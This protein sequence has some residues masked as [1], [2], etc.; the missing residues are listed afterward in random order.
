VPPACADYERTIAEAVAPYLDAFSNYG[1]E[2][3][4]D[5]KLLLFRSNRGGRSSQL[6][7]APAGKPAARP[8]VIAEAKDGVA[9]ARFTPDGRYLLFLRDRDKDE[10]TQIYRATP[11]GKE[12]R[13]LTESPQAYHR[14][15]EVTADGKTLF[16]FTGTHS[17][18]GITLVSQSIEGGAARKIFEGQ[19]FH[20][21][22]AITRDGRQALVFTLKS[23]SSSALMRV[24]LTSGATRTLAPSEGKQAHAHLSAFSA[25]EKSVYVVTDEDVERAGLHRIDL[26]S[27]AVLARYHDPKAEVADVRVSPRARVVAVQLDAGSHHLIKLL[28]ATTLKP[29]VTVRLPKGSV[30]LG[31]FSADGKGL[32]ITLSVPDAPTDVHYL[33]VGGGVRPLRRDARPGLAKLAKINVRV[34]WVPSTDDVHVPIN[35]YQPRPL[36]DKRLPVIVSVHGGPAAASSIGWSPMVSFWVS[37]G[38]AVVEPNVRGSTGFGKAYEKADNGRK[39]LN[40]LKDLAA[41][42]EWTRRQDWADPQRMVVFGASYGGYM[43]YMALGHQP[44]RWQ[45]GLGAVGV[46][47]LETFLRTTT[48]AIQLVFRDEFGE[49]PRDAEFLRSVSPIAVVDRIRAPLFVYQGAK[50]PRVPRSEQDQ[51]VTALR[52]RKVPVEYMVAP[53]EGHSLSQRHNRREYISRTQRFLE[54]HLDLPGPPPACKAA[55]LGMSR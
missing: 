10:N 9:A 15:P 24:D 25:D 27:G 35:V 29:R 7:V 47:N 45:A 30:Q 13:A 8:T 17:S 1:E 18:R 48:G 43:T 23:L 55:M 39:R 37:R 41:V 34:K 53:D 49:L 46:V 33:A 36:G 5:G 44:E 38:F 12:V 16:Y 4:P 14:L 50:D 40:A 21:L 22:T 32:V 20:Y 42:N 52:R 28:D 3:S 11:D 31:R 2:L 6:Y 54:V 51:L 19:G 26:S